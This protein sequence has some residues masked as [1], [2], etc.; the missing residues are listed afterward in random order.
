MS[1]AVLEINDVAL[2]IRSESGAT[3]SEP[4]FA[5]LTAQGLDCGE[6][7][8]AS[9][10]K[11]SQSNF[12]QYWQQLGESPLMVKTRSARHFADI[13]FAQ[14][15]QMFANFDDVNECILAIPVSFTDQQLSLLMGMLNALSVK[16]HAVIDSALAACLNI[17]DAPCAYLEFQQHQAVATAFS[18][19]A[20]QLDIAEQ[21][22]IPDLGVTR[23]YNALAHQIARQLIHSS[24]F[25]P[26]HD[27]ALEQWLFDHLPEWLAQLQWQAELNLTMATPAGERPFKLTRT[28]VAAE[29][30]DRFSPLKSFVGR[31]CGVSGVALAVSSTGAPFAGLTPLTASAQIVSSTACVD[32]GLKFLHPSN[33]NPDAL[34]RIRTFTVEIAPDDAGKAKLQNVCVLHN[35]CAVSLQQPVSLTIQHGEVR[36]SQGIEQSAQLVI[37]QNGLVLQVLHKSEGTVSVLPQQARAGEMLSVDGVQFSLITLLGSESDNG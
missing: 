6:L 31:Y 25:D 4:G 15:K 1:L 17:N 11:E 14:L 20:D 18:K 32:N 30:S 16:T 29:L 35:H 33:F 22:V 7:A 21:E 37:V 34:R 2:T 27:P 3:Y 5:R 19:V 36:L 24:R 10:W 26:L 13:A 8:R 23:L 9:A 12:N 28:D